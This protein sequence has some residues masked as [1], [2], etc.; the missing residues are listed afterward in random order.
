MPREILY[1]HREKKKIKIPI[2]KNSSD[3]KEFCEN[4]NLFSIFFRID[5]MS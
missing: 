5:F 1:I 2:V 4:L 3:L